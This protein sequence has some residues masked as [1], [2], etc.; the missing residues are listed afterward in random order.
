VTVLLSRDE[1]TTTGYSLALVTTDVATAG[2]HPDAIVAR[3]ARRW[4]IEVSYSD[5]TVTWPPT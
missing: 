5:L 4:P 3:Y 2:E 1:H